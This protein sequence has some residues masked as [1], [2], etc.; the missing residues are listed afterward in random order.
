MVEQTCNSGHDKTGG[1]SRKPHWK[2]GLYREFQVSRF[3]GLQS[4]S[5]SWKRKKK[6]KTKTKPKNLVSEIESSDTAISPLLVPHFTKGS[7]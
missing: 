7:K 5:L 2:L 1:W 4:E 6:Q 3:L